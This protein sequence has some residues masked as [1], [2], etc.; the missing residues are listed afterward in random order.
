MGPRLRIKALGVTAI[1]SSE[2]T[3]KQEWLLRR[4]C[5]LLKYLV[6]R[7]DEVVSADECVEA[8]WPETRGEGRN[9]VR[10][11]IFALREMLEPNRGRRGASSFVVTLGGGYALNRHRVEIDI[12]EFE[13]LITSGPPDVGPS[14]DALERAMEIYRGDL[15]SEEHYAEWAFAESER[16]RELA[17]WALRRLA[18]ARLEAGDLHGAEQAVLRLASMCPLDSRTHCAEIAICIAR[19]DWSQASR[20][21]ALYRRRLLRVLGTEPDFSLAGLARAPVSAAIEAL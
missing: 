20:W 15:F 14:M 8:L 4:P 13:A 17:D 6:C 11:A 12:D 7:R 5:Q 21:Y 1:E 3:V 10:Q 2:G 9:S 16:L 18:I 19:G